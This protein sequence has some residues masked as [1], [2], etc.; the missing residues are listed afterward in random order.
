MQKD[1]TIITSSSINNI[2]PESYI[3]LSEAESF[4]KPNA[5]ALID[6]VTNF[7]LILTIIIFFLFAYRR[8]LE[9]LHYI[10]TSF[11]SLKKVLIIE[12]QSNTQTSR[13]TL[14]LFSVVV[15]SF[16][17]ANH[18]HENKFTDNAYP[19]IIN[20]AIILLFIL[21]YFL[22]KR[23][24]LY[25]ISWINFNGIFITINK[26]FYSY[27]VLGILLSF[28]G[29]IINIIFNNSNLTYTPLYISIGMFLAFLLY[30]IR[31][32]QLIIANGFSH[33]FYILYLCT[34]EIL[35]LIF[36]AHLIFT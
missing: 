17:I 22:F 2:W 29:I 21:G 36:L 11:M 6:N 18:N 1:S 33:F 24:S 15:S 30:F 31:G 32:Y 35:P 9:G 4:S 26:I 16:I 27:T 10:L 13:N 23:L 19:I 34:L 20:F 7:G 25:L 3:A 12:N 28:I 5:P 8:I 14:L